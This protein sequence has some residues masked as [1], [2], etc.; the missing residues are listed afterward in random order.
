MSMNE[1]M[2]I[3]NKRWNPQNLICGYIVMS[4]FYGELET[5]RDV[6]HMPLS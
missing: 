5:G 4:A 1:N 3:T 2:N 6:F